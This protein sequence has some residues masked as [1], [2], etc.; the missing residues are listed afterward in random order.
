M[1]HDALYRVA[2]IDYSYRNAANAWSTTGHPATDWRA[3]QDAIVKVDPMR[4][5]PAPMV[6]DLPDNR[7]VNLTY[8]YD[9]L[10]NQTEWVDDAHA[11]Y[12]R[13]LGST[14][15][16]GYT[17]GEANGGALRPTAL[18]LAAQLPESPSSTIDPSIDR[19]G[20]VRVRYGESGNATSVTVR[21]RCHDVSAATACWD[22][23]DEQDVDQRASQLL[24]TCRCDQEQHYEY[25]WDE[26]NRLA[27]ARRYDRAGSGDWALE[28][29]QRYRYDAGNIRTLKETVD[30]QSA[31]PGTGHAVGGVERVALYV[32]PGDFER[33]GLVVNRVTDTYDASVALGTETQ[34]LVAGARVVWKPGAVGGGGTGFERD[35]RVTLAMSNLLQS[36]AGVVDLVSG[37]LLEVATYYPNGAR[38]TL[39]ANSDVDPFALEPVGFTGK[40]DDS[41]V[42]LVY[43][44]M[45]YLMPHLG[46]WASPD[47]LQIHAGG[48]GEFGNSYHYVSGNLLQAR[49]PNGLKATIAQHEATE[50]IDGR[51]VRVTTR[52][53][54]MGYLVAPGGRQ[55]TGGGVHAIT[56]KDLER[57]AKDLRA[58]LE[59]TYQS[60]EIEEDGRI[61]RYE[62]EFEVEI[63][64]DDTPVY[65]EGNE[66]MR[67]RGAQRRGTSVV[68]EA[69]TRGL[70]NAVIVNPTLGG[71]D[72]AAALAIPGEDPRQPRDTEVGGQTAASN[73]ILVDRHADERTL[74]HE[75]AHTLGIG[76]QRAAGSVTDRMLQRTERRPASAAD[77]RARPLSESDQ[78]RLHNAVQSG[79]P[80]LVMPPRMQTEGTE[81][82]HVFEE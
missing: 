22:D 36:T 48:G 54:H 41:E 46:R 51:D 69:A 56:R 40:E 33:R 47:P 61:Y 21:A 62:F 67:P 12:E 29:R 42:G 4:R 55:G 80:G 50:R 82:A 34:Y 23:S 6:G 31:D 28:V 25:R 32:M 16:N 26:L 19:G 78:Q 35:A 27:E 75:A 30:G 5:R 1:T 52:T 77:G 11:F 14:I 3:T 24:A 72:P 49:D 65:N 59:T 58:A 17:D 70:E 63:S 68:A 71:Q 18:Y 45:R 74:A 13:S 8:R 38:E 66:E 79:T 81:P 53:I 73:V 20:W 37:E 9:W 10:A 64:D 44:G 15:R 57:A 39:R 76:H 2:N 7:V 60:F 43:F